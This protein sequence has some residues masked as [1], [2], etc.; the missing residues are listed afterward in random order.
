MDSAAEQVRRTSATALR[1]RGG[2]PPAVKLLPC[3]PA[4]CNTQQRAAKKQA[5]A[6]AAAAQD[7]LLGEEQEAGGEGEASD[8]EAPDRFAEITRMHAQ[9]RN[10]VT[11]RIE[12][13]VPEICRTEPCVLGIDEAGRGPVMGTFAG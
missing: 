8:G 6:D 11:E 9:V 1:T 12:S 7:A 3:N 4:A 2:R 13:D 10:R 5:A